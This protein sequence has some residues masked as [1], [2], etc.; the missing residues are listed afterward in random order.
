MVS[1]ILLA[2]EENIFDEGVLFV[3]FLAHSSMLCLAKNAG[4]YE[5]SY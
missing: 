4:S 2:S 1:E 3:L 5:K